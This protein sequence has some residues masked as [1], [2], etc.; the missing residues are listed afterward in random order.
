VLKYVYTGLLDKVFRT[1]FG[2]KLLAVAWIPGIK[3]LCYVLMN[4]RSP[5]N[6][7]VAL[8]WISCLQYARKMVRV[9]VICLALKNKYS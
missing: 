6:S 2:L 9:C 5:A 7:T 4:A 8:R 1:V 3:S